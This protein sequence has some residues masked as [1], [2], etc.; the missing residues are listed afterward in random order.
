MSSRRKTTIPTLI[1]LLLRFIPLLLA[2]V[3]ANSATATT[4]DDDDDDSHVLPPAAGGQTLTR[5]NLRRS[6]SGSG[7]GSEGERSAT[8]GHRERHLLDDNFGERRHNVFDDRHRHRHDDE[9][10]SSSSSSSVQN[11]DDGRTTAIVLYSSVS[12]RRAAIDAADG[13]VLYDLSGERTVVVR[14]DASGAGM[15]RLEQLRDAGDLT[16]ALDSAIEGVDVDDSTIVP[17]TPEEEDRWRRRRHLESS[18]SSAAAGGGYEA[19]GETVP[20]GL[21]MMQADQLVSGSSKR[22]MVCSADS[23]YAFHPDLPPYPTVNGLDI[24]TPSGERLWWHIDGDSIEHHTHGTVMAGIIGA[25]PSN[26]MGIRGVVDPAK[27]RMFNTRA[28]GNDNRSTQA[29]MLDAISQCVDAGADVVSVAMGCLDCYDPVAEEFFRGLYEDKGVVVVAAAGNTGLTGGQTSKFYPASY[30][31]VISAAAVDADGERMD[32]SNSNDAV[33]LAA[34]GDG[35]MSTYLG[36]TG[37]TFGYAYMKGTSAATAY[38][39]GAAAKL[40]THFPACSNDEI[41]NA[42]AFTAVN[43]K[44]R[45]T[46]N[47]DTGRGVVRLLDAYDYLRRV[48]CRGAKKR[49]SGIEKTCD[50]PVGGQGGGIDQG[51]GGGNGGAGGCRDARYTTKVRH[52]DGR[53]WSCKR[54]RNEVL[55]AKWQWEG[56]HFV[57]AHWCDETISNASTLC[58]RLC[59][60]STVKKKKN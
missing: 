37:S 33:E 34:H 53:L 47:E 22:V 27:V 59:R 56:H 36:A 10:L 20:V 60:R 48:G 3:A 42:L 52:V 17:L 6:G 21:T 1:M 24:T 29:Q 5:G 51:G 32:L 12:A 50:R 44:W 16:F 49:L 38:I 55:E 39:A 8:G 41:R 14:V 11:F 13:E 28:L 31:S 18:T 19:N 4:V 40:W 25:E 58:P 7:G 35:V 23:G 9:P 45:G 54:I 57:R 46:C 26:S 30:E 43:N 2:F 15:E